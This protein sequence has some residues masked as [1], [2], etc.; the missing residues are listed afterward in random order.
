MNSLYGNSIQCLD[1]LT[2]LV[3]F[4]GND[5]GMSTPVYIKTMKARI[6]PPGC[7]IYSEEMMTY[8]DISACNCSRGL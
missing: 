3:E 4:Q 5:L 2:D 8:G 6:S 1:A 7:F